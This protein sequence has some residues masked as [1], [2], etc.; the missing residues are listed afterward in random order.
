MGDPKKKHKTYSTPKRPYDPDTLLDELRLIGTYG[1]RNKRELWKAH[2]ILSTLRRRAR[3]LLS[4]GA[5]ERSERQAEMVS[6][7]HRLGLVRE[8]AT[9]EEVLT[10]TIEDFLERRLQTMVYRKDLSHSLYQARQ[11]ITHGHIAINGQKVT[12]PG[13]HVTIEDENT[14]DYSRW[15]PYMDPDHPFRREMTIE[16]AIGGE[17]VEQ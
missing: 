4:L 11:M 1:L 16:E 7:L 17:E 12:A 10:L 5:G 6:R 3:E 14:L 2:T 15:S 9:L 8:G 13:Y